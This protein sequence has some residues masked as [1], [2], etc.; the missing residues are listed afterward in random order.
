MNKEMDFIV[1]MLIKKNILTLSVSANIFIFVRYNKKPVISLA[2][3]Q[4]I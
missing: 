4:L 1:R 2:H 3:K